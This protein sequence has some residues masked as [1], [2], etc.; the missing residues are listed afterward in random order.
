MNTNDSLGDRMKRYELSSRT[1]L[2]QRLPVIIRVDGKAFH[3]YTRNLAR[4]FDSQFNSVMD[5]VANR[6]CEEIDGAQVAYIQ[7]DEISVLVHGYKRLQTTP[8]F[9]NQ[10]Q[11]MV[12]VSAGVASAYFT[13]ASS[14]IFGAVRPAVFD[15]RVFVVPERDVCNYFIWRQND[16]SRNSLQMLARSLYSH[17]Q[18]H[19]KGREELHELIHAKGQ[20]WNN[21]PTSLKRGRCVVREET[22]SEQVTPDG[23]NVVVRHNWVVDNETPIF[24]SDRQYIEKFLATEET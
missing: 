19:E 11:K 9:D 6:L 5:I 24:T 14:A 3:T 21:M 2:C 8:W 1:Q 12:S 13:E 18:L 20:N 16:A 15:S 7:S 22:V 4:P 10:V 23:V 17:K